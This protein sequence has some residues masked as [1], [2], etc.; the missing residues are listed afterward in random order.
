VEAE[1]LGLPA[2][3][4]LRIQ[5]AEMGNPGRSVSPYRGALKQQNLGLSYKVY[6]P[7]SPF[8]RR[9]NMILDATAPHTR[10]D[11]F[12]IDEYGDKIGAYGLAVYTIIKRHYNWATGQCTPSYNRIAQMCKISRSTVKRAVK[13]LKAFGLI[14]AKMRFADDGQTSNQ[15]GFYQPQ[16]PVKK[17]APPVP[18][19]TPPVQTSTITQMSP[20][21]SHRPPGEALQ[22]PKQVFSEQVKEKKENAKGVPL[23]EGKEEKTQGTEKPVAYEKTAP[24]EKTENQKKCLHPY[25]EVVMLSDGVTICNHCFSLID[26]L[27]DAEAA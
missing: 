4:K 10:I 13:S 27:P 21:G 15:Y 5:G 16:R 3:E 8:S 17:P 2:G 11:N 26:F 19:C 22:N 7:G 23:K 1:K 25:S 20:P 6:S 12:V 24:T 9:I 14:D 18:A